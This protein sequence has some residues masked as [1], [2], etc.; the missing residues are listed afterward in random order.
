MS[1]EDY[2]IYYNC[3]RKNY[4]KPE[5]VC[6]PYND[7]LKI[8]YTSRIFDLNNKPVEC[9]ETIIIPVPSWIPSMFHKRLLTSELRQRV[10]TSIQQD[11]KDQQQ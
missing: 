11:Q 1:V 10:I 6:K 3:I 9:F 8:P 5:F 2:F 7:P 4:F